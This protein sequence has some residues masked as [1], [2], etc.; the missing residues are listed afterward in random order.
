LKLISWN[1]QRGFLRK[2]KYE[3]ILNIMPNIA[4]IKEC[5][6]PGSLKDTLKHND[7]IWAG[8]EDGIGIG[9]FYPNIQNW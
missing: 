7:V 6:H 4:L 8:K 5:V 3:K 2:E 1:C 9:V